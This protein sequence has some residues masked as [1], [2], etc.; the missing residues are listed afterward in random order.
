M[1]VSEKSHKQSDIN[2]KIGRINAIS[3]SAI[4]FKTAAFDDV[5]V[6][7]KKFFFFEKMIY[8]HVLQI[9]ISYLSI[10]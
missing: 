10:K 5:V 8:V 3:G 4:F 9:K 6:S 2:K 7:M 1:N